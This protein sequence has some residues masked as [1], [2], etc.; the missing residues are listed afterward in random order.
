MTTKGEKPSFNA[1]SKPGNSTRRQSGGRRSK[2]VGSSESS[3]LQKKTSKSSDTST[4]IHVIT[5]AHNKSDVGTKSQR[6]AVAFSMLCAYTFMVSD[7][8]SVKQHGRHP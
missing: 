8:A 4:I 1:R 7:R 2:V 5:N 6:S 3:A